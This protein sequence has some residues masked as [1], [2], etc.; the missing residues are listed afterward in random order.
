MADE[1]IVMYTVF[2]FEGQIYWFNTL[3]GCENW[4]DWVNVDWGSSE[5]P[6][7]LLMFFISLKISNNNFTFLIEKLRNQVCMHLV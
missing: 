5:I 1:Y 6:A 7:K 3:Y 4:H 2:K